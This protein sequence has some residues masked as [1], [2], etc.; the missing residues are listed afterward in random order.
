MYHGM[1]KYAQLQYA[2]RYYP[3][4]GDLQSIAG[5]VEVDRHQYTCDH[6]GK[7][8]AFPDQ[9]Q[10]PFYCHSSAC[11]AVKLVSIKPIQERKGAR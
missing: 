1:K 9:A 5:I 7:N 8:Y 11:G 3:G 2:S 10:E 6:C 4:I